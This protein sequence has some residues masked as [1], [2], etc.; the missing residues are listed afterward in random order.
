MLAP[1]CLCYAGTAGIQHAMPADMRAARRAARDPI[2]LALSAAYLLRPSLCAGWYTAGMPEN[3]PR[4]D[5]Q[6]RL[7]ACSEGLVENAC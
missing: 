3:L 1:D 6:V 5:G 4:F 2:L 7:R